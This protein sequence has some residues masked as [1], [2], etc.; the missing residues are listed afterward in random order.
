MRKAESMRSKLSDLPN[1]TSPLKFFKTQKKVG[2]GVCRTGRSK[3]CLAEHVG[4]R[5][6]NGPTCLITTCQ[7][8]VTLAELEGVDQGVRKRQVC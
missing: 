8:V 3:P 5:F 7:S 2:I 1:L 6:R 4:Q